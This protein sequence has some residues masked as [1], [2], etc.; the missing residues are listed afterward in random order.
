MRRSGS[1][2]VPREPKGSKGTS[3]A[4]FFQRP[5]SE[6]LANANGSGLMQIVG[7]SRKRRERSER[8]LA[9]ERL[10]AEKGPERIW[11]WKGKGKGSAEAA[12]N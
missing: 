10:E 2:L 6:L 8:S 11:T 5:T 7:A 9:T 1:A 12:G 3:L 4:A